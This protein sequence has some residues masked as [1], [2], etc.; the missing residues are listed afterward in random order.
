VFRTIVFCFIITS[1]NVTTRTVL[2]IRSFSHAMCI[3]VDDFSYKFR[4]L[5]ELWLT[6]RQWVA[7][8]QKIAT[9]R[10]LESDP[11]VDFYRKKTWSA[12][13]RLTHDWNNGHINDSRKRSPTC[14]CEMHFEWRQSV[15][16]GLRL[17]GLQ[18]DILV[19]LNGSEAHCVLRTSFATFDFDDFVS[20]RMIY[21]WIYKIPKTQ[22]IIK[23]LLIQGEK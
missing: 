21:L 11:T 14:T 19:S 20:S 7:V 9:Q 4:H 3:R 10:K 23:K 1:K 12:D 8:T 15:V 16:N 5:S 2:S 6:V 13:H 17:R 22:H 18:P